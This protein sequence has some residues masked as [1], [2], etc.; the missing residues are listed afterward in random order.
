MSSCARSNWPSRASAQIAPRSGGAGNTRQATSAPAPMRTARTAR[1]IQ[2]GARDRDVITMIQFMS[3]GS[4]RK[5]HAGKRSNAEMPTRGIIAAA[6]NGTARSSAALARDIRVVLESSTVVSGP[7]PLFSGRAVGLQ[8][9]HRDPP[10]QQGPDRGLVQ[11]RVT[12]CTSGRRPIRPFT[13]WSVT[14]SGDHLN[15]ASFQKVPIPDLQDQ[16]RLSARV[17]YGLVQ[18]PAARTTGLAQSGAKWPCFRRS[19]SPIA[20][21]R[22]D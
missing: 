3:T 8:G 20:K 9:H 10:V 1:T 12:L 18:S 17:R 6:T 22:N 11:S 14:L 5:D 2:F 7:R 19:S 15:P 21:P 16:R 4:L 13:V